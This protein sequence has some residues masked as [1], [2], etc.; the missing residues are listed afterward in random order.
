MSV[1]VKIIVTRSQITFSPK[2]QSTKALKS[3]LVPFVHAS[4]A[5]LRP[6]SL[7]IQQFGCF[8]TAAAQSLSKPA[9]DAGNTSLDTIQGLLTAEVTKQL[10]C[11]TA[12]EDPAQVWRSAGVLLFQAPAYQRY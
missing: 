2:L 3:H 4:T 8:I 6:V 1:K 12:A 7:V 9:D 10:C 11:I 5:V